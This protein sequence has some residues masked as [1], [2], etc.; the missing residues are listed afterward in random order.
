[1]NE[2]RE[3]ENNTKEQLTV[4]EDKMLLRLSSGERSAHLNVVIFAT[5]RFLMAES[6]A[7][8]GC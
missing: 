7:C 3:K 8:N 6:F 4:P 2:Q 5:R 1:M